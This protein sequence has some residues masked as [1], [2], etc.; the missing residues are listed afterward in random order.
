[1]LLLALEMVEGIVL[2]LLLVLLCFC[3]H[4]PLVLATSASRLYQSF[5]FCFVSA[6]QL[7]VASWKQGR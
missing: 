2:R 7:F 3:W 1:M 5:L 6:K 4:V